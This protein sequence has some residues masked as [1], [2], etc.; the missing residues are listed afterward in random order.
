MTIEFTPAGFDAFQNNITN[1]QTVGIGT[2]NPIGQ[3]QVGS[4]TSTFIVTGIGS[5]GIGTIN[6]TASLT[7]RAGGIAANSAPLKISAGT[8]LLST[9]EAGAF[10]YDNV[11]LYHTQND[12][13]NGN[14]R[15]LIPEIQY[16]RRTAQLSITAVATPGTSIFGATSRPALLAGTIYEVETIV[17]LSKVTTAG[18][19][20]FQFSLSGS[21]FTFASL[22]LSTSS[23]TQVLNGT[24]SPVSF[25]ATTSLGVGTYGVLIRGIVQP[26]SN[27]R[28]DILAF[29]STTSIN[30]EPSSY[31]KVTCLGLSA[32]IGN[33]A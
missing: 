12:T 32:T 26:V 30:I 28:L 8:S 5:V 27:A 20:T 2:T 16:Q 3:L 22:Q 25:P 18:T 9:P 4:G 17:W 24:T 31:M 7:I 23:T 1:V 21:N 33:F 11:L 14:K 15:A 29:G 10:E 13:T 19:V 6:P